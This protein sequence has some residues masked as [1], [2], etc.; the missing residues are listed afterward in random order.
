LPGAP[1]PLTS[2]SL[3]STE[4]SSIFPTN[5]HPAPYPR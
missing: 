1:S 3:R 5:S 2:S 4:R